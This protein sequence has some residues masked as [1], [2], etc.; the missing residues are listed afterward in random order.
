MERAV[1]LTY[2]KGRPRMQKNDLWGF[3]SSS[4]AETLR[5]PN[6]NPEDKVKICIQQ[7]TASARTRFSRMGMVSV[8]QGPELGTMYA[9]LAG[10]TISA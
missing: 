2:P 6:P 5:T 7:F 3:T 4:K 8:N 9:A 10:H 1:S